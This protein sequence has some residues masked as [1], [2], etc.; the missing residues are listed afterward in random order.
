MLDKTSSI[1]CAFGL[2]YAAPR[3]PYRHLELCGIAL[4]F[5]LF[6]YT[7]GEDTRPRLMCILEPCG[8]AIKNAASLPAKEG[9]IFQVRNYVIKRIAA[10][11]CDPVLRYLH[12]LCDDPQPAQLFCREHGNAAVPGTGRKTVS[13]MAGSAQRCL[14][15]GSGHPARL[16]HLAVQRVGGNFGDSWKWNVPATQK[17]TGS[18]R[19]VCYHG[20]HLLCAVHRD[21]CA[22]RRAGCYQAVQPHGLRHHRCG[23]GRHFAAHLLLCHAAQ[24]AVLG[25]ARLV[26]PV[27]PRRT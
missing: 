22:P 4:N 14:R 8:A 1:I 9:T 3:S 20:R 7:I 25:Q 2:A 26:R 5:R 17:F 24:A 12:H 15:S 6:R 19:S 13:G 11:F 27:R 16:L 10:F 18:H 23:A 21:R